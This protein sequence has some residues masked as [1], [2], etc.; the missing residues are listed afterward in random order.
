MNNIVYS[1]EF[2]IAFITN[3]KVACTTIK[4]SLLKGKVKG[5]V[6]KGKLFN[7]TQ[8]FDTKL[9]CLTRN[10][11][12][13]ALSAYRDKIGPDSKARAWDEFC[14]KYKI[15]KDKHISFF[16]FL[17][18]LDSDPDIHNFD[19][20]FRSQYI[21]LHH[22]SI[23]PDF[24]GRIENIK[25]VAEFLNERGIELLT[26]R[27][28]KTNSS[29]S[30]REIITEPEVKLIERIYKKDFDTYGY[31][32]SL[33]SHFI[34]PTIKQEQKTS[35][36]YIEYLIMK[37]SGLTADELR[38]LGIKKENNSNIGAAHFLMN[39]ALKARPDGH[40]IKKKLTKYK[41]ELGFI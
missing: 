11:Y 39:L 21:N 3:P 36:E 40:V 34:P 37:K 16:E 10:P 12:S 26:S 35:N 6:H 23:K 13:R 41:K 15:N 2:D 24:I 22:E 5:S 14:D 38:D 28:H 17:T 27:P 9:F 32:M 29:K 8:D 7:Y 25:D 20:H 4:N 33:K 31:E 30:Y 1:R 18:I 19:Q